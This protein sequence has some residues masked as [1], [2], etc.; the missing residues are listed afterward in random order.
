MNPAKLTNQKSTQPGNPFTRRTSPRQQGHAA[1]DKAASL[2]NIMQS[3]HPAMNS[4]P[5]WLWFYPYKAA[6]PADQVLNTNY[7]PRQPTYLIDNHFSKEGACSNSNIAAFLF[8]TVRAF[9]EEYHAELN[10]I[11]TARA[12]LN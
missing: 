11:Q 6:A 5:V 7:P 10:I 8:L 2:K 1:E 12:I 3:L 4:A 9:A